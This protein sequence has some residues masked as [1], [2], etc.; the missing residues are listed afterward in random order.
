MI[1]TRLAN[2][3][4]Q[5]DGIRSLQSSN[6]RKNLSEA[7]AADQ[8]FLIAEYDPDYLRRMNASQ[9]PVVALDEDRVIGYALAATHA[10]RDGHPLLADLFLQINQLQFRGEPL[11]GVNYVVVAQLCVARNYRGIGLVNQLYKCFRESLQGHYRHAI[12]DVARANRRSLN[13]HLKTGFQRI[14][15]ISYDALEWDVLLWDWSEGSSNAGSALT[16]API[17]DAS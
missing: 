1:I 15:E 2:R 16:R 5:M 9:P 8:G 13:A 10:V 17:T 14:H 11:K 7:E 3:E 6:L 4:S 12:T